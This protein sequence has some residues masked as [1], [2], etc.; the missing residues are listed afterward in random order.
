MKEEKEE[1]ITLLNVEEMA[2]K[3]KS[4][5]G[6]VYGWVSLKKIPEWCIVRPGRSLRFDNDKVNQWLNSLRAAPLPVTP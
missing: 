1:D 2:Q 5:V 4:T 3:I 6:T